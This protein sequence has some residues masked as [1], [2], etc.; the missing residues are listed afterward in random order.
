[1]PTNT[2]TGPSGD[3]LLAHVMPEAEYMYGCTPTA[4]AM[5][6][7]YYDLYGY[8]GTDLSNMIEGD[9]DS[10]SRGPGLEAYDMDAFDTALG[11]ATAT[12]SFVSRFHSRGGKETTP[13]QEL[14][15]SFKSGKKEIRT[16]VWDCLADYLGT[17]QYW[18]GNDNL[19]TTLSY[20]SL[21][22]LYKNDREYEVSA[23][24]TTRTIRYIETAMLYGLDLYVQSRGYELDYEITG[25]Y[26][27]DVAGGSF[28]FADY[29]RE[30]DAGRPVMI[31]IQGHSMTGYG[32]NAE[33]QEIIFDDC[34]VS[35][36]RMKWDGTYRFDKADRKLQSIVVIGI[37]A[38]GNVDLAIDPVPGGDGE[39]LIVSDA[40]DAQESAPYC[41]AG[42]SVYL[43]FTVSNRGTK[44][45]GDFSAV[46]R[47]DGETVSSGMLDE[48]A[49]GDSRG[50]GGI[51]LG[52]LSIGLH[53]V[54]V[55][56][57]DANDI[58]EL[59]G[60][61]NAAETDLLVLKPG[62]N[63]VSSLLTVDL[64]KTVRDVCVLGGGRL[65]LTDGQ[66]S[67]AVLHGKIVSNSG[68]SSSWTSAEAVV[69]QGGYASGA[70]VWSY[71]AL[72]VSGGGCAADVRVTA[73]GSMYVRSGGTASDVEIESG[74]RLMVSSGGKL[75]GRIRIAEGASARINSGGVLD[76]DLSAL[77]PGTAARVNDLSRLKGTPVYTLTVSGMQENG[78][79][80]LA[81]G[82]GGFNQ[83]I[84]VR[85][86][87]GVALCSL[88]AGETAK[89]NGMEYALNLDAD[90]SLSL[91]VSGA[92]LADLVAPTVSGIRLDVPAPTCWSVTVFADFHD[93]MALASK[94]YRIGRNGAWTEYTDGVT[95]GE[96]T[97]V[98]FKAVDAAGNESEIVSRTVSNITS[99][100]C[101]FS[102]GQTVDVLSASRFSDT[103]LSGG[104]M[105]ISSGGAADG[106]AACDGGRMVVSSGG[107]ASGATIDPG[108]ELA[109]LPGAHVSE[110]TVNSDGCAGIGS[111][112]VADGVA[113]NS[114]GRLAVQEGGSITGRMTFADGADV[115]FAPKSILNFDLAFLAPGADAPV[116]GISLVQGA[117]TFTLTVSG[118][119]EKG[120]YRLADG[121]GEFDAT[122]S[123]RNIAGPLYAELEIGR[124]VD[125][126]GAG[127]S[128]NR[129]DGAL[130]LTVGAAGID[131]GADC[132][133]N[134]FLYDKKAKTLNA[135][136]ADSV[137]TVL[138]AGTTGIQLDSEGSVLKDGRC[139]FVGFADDADYLK[140][141]L[142]SAANLSFTI[143]ATD[144]AKFVVYRLVET[145]KDKAGNPAY[146]LKSLQ[147]KTLE[148][149]KDFTG[150]TGPLLLEKGDYYISVQSTNAK[151][152]ASAYYS[153]SLNHDSGKTVFYSDGDD[154]GN[155]WLYD[156]KTKK[157]NAAVSGVAGRTL[158]PGNLQIDDGA[159]SCEG[160]DGW[161]NFVGFGDE[162]DFAKLDLSGTANVQFTVTA[163]NAAKFVIYRLVETGKDK[164]GDP[165]YKLKTV[166]TKTLKKKKSGDS[167]VYTATMTKPLELQ[168]AENSEYFIAVKSTNA[169]K[170]K[171]AYY[172]VTLDSFEAADGA[173]LL[174]PD[175]VQDK[176][177]LTA[178][179]ASS[180]VPA[181]PESAS[182][183]A[184]TV[185]D[186]LFAGP[187][188]ARDVSLSAALPD[189]VP[190]RLYGESAAGLL[191]A[192]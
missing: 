6:L 62:T 153:V 87:N 122:V 94:W 14:K 129:S 137:A 187:D 171:I 114:G 164:Y 79:Y 28:T 192:L 167:Y 165:T 186:E 76:F 98:Y 3:V 44:D 66:A 71:A 121:A 16:D 178:P 149:K 106:T 86:T 77:A 163:S 136:I 78:V 174:R 170:G 181:A 173:A 125:I 190:D 117:P 21:E 97:V 156:K 29:M 55:V 11:R 26:A 124:T 96:N 27:V 126:N 135:R 54:R 7:G 158:L 74:G 182:D 69:A 60:S 127:Y 10:K 155:N 110:I 19:S 51:S 39:K 88:A 143:D 101:T 183:A 180:S 73:K 120:L 64:Q 32:Y 191:A 48:L 13:A 145:G 152:N 68:T 160:S 159:P 2:S 49:G 100:G 40:P 52:E 53:N 116:N 103:V 90:G 85:D 36:R 104:S 102:G 188:A 9:V 8:R 112:S 179:E 157:A 12:E 4:V 72:D 166:L 185:P 59:S 139:N 50:I 172:N 168:A 37:N 58:Q 95:V 154:G 84:S 22:D 15:Y 83:T 30:I 141:R 115:S 132:G 147:T 184:L 144:A 65:V 140:I 150:T 61:N 130:T 75:T 113:V 109:L 128:L 111:S 41:F 189:P 118:F 91:A 134:N 131:N 18:R 47:V 31:S 42:D 45:S 105:R 70:T 67:G 146:K 151:K 1:M 108:G 93:D 161:N 162:A 43:S 23:G 177:A 99:S 148:K 107:T 82:A 169:A 63:V 56:L 46:I 133:W 20:G 123:V 81:D 142:D 176:S 119:Q 17:G 138:R 25:C 33:T 5:I 38:N 57:D 35:G 175:S 89:W 92:P 34:Y 24:S 80:R